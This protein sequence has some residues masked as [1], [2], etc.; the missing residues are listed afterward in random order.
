M[1]WLRRY[2]PAELCGLLCA[3]TGSL[4]VRGA[5]G[6]AAAAAYAGAIAESV[7]FY[8]FLL[9]RRTRSLWALVVE[10]GPAEALDSIVVR[11]ACIAGAMS[12]L[13]PV[14]GVVAGKLA[15][16]LVFYTPVIAT[17]ELGLRRERRLTS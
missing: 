7:G 8:G 1:R 10:F 4:L 5:I 16:D 2:A 3:L 12:L 17:Y 15:A 9:A 11:P 13:G 6:N 14:A